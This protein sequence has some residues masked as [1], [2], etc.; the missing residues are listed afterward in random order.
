MVPHKSRKYRAILNLSLSFKLFGMTIPSANE[1]TVITAPQHSMCQL[2][3]V[4][5]HLIQAVATAPVD[6]GM[7]VFSKLDIDDGY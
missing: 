7:M 6:K 5:S 4:L 3:L 1:E 2:G